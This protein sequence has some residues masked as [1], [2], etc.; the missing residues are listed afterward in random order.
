MTEQDDPLTRLSHP[1]HV[2]A[3]VPVGAIIDRGKR[4]KR[5]R[6]L[7]VA[8]LTSVV[9]VTLAVV[10]V[11][12]RSGDG[13]SVI[14]GQPTAGSAE[15]SPAGPVEPPPGPTAPAVA[16]GGRSLTETVVD[17]S[18]DLASSPI[19]VVNGTWGDYAHDLA[20][21]LAEITYSLG[22][23]FGGFQV[24]PADNAPIAESSIVY[25]T[26]E[27][28]HAATELAATIGIDTD[29]VVLGDTSIEQ[30]VAGA[31]GPP[32]V[33]DLVF[34][35]GADLDT[36]GGECSI[37]HDHLSCSGYRG[38]LLN[39]DSSLHPPLEVR[40]LV[41]NGAAVDGLAGDM[42]ERLI[43]RGYPLT[44]ATTA[45][46]AVADSVVYFAP[47]YEL[48]A[49]SVWQRLFPTDGRAEIVVPIEEPLPLDDRGDAHVVVIL[50]SDFDPP[51]SPKD[52]SS[53]DPTSAELPFDALPGWR[54]TQ[55]DSEDA[56]DFVWRVYSAQRIG[57]SEAELVTISLTTAS[58]VLIPPDGLAGKTTTVAG[59]EVSVE[60]DGRRTSVNFVPG[61][62]LLVTIT[63]EAESVTE[64]DLLRL[65]EHLEWTP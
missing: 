31:S 13:G 41:A 51:S 47:G 23:G 53:F 12:Q 44:T 3:P 43:D 28:A 46:G 21:D 62:G 35:V 5:R 65:V 42:V 61:D 25:R 37:A 56:D 33:F 20:E 1:S 27:H 29:R 30:W 2:A 17:L 24:A 50:G 54:L 19:L 16:P 8:S 45:T 10:G 48:D 60:P 6:R 64:G 57:D 11:A 38:P 7:A 52:W 9:V 32:L 34:V 26:Q 22:N 15:P 63:S 14:A 58:D 59:L 36:E 49:R 18:D 40:V 4:I 39:P 55:V